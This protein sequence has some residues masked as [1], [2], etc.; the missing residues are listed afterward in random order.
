MFPTD[1]I[2]TVFDN[3]SMRIDISSGR[4][5]LDLWDTAG[6]PDYRRL[7]PLSYPQT[8]IFLVCYSVSDPS[9]YNDVKSS[10]LPEI[11]EY[12]PGVPNILVGCKI[13]ER[14]AAQR[15]GGVECITTAQGVHMAKE[16]GART[17]LECSALTGL[18][19]EKVL[20]TA[21][22]IGMD[23]VSGEAK[24]PGCIVC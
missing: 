3:Y 11:Q 7:R 4:I 13:D 1:Y 2:P 12:S 5:H 23:P 20:H 6:S 8:N 22:E 15:R 21:A 9:S 16:I 10:W 24:T 17:Y 18:G 14:D 19:V